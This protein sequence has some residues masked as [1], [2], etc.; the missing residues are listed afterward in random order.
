[1]IQQSLIL[2]GKNDYIGIHVSCRFLHRVKC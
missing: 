1:M 2:I